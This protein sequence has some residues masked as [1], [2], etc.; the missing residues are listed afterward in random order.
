[1]SSCVG[2]TSPNWILY[3]VISQVADNYVKMKC[4][5]ECQGRDTEW[6]LYRSWTSCF[7][8]KLMLLTVVSLLLNVRER[9]QEAH[10]FH[11]SSRIF[12]TECC[13]EIRLNLNSGNSWTILEDI[14]H[15]HKHC[16]VSNCIT[17]S[18]H[19]RSDELDDALRHVMSAQAH[20]HYNRQQRHLGTRWRK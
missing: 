4:K 13:F 10:H 18:Q 8:S 3:E 19:A 14:R 12:S 16:I 5:S 7:Q 2:R 9:I 11:M 6:K 17:S 1:M 20:F 15:D